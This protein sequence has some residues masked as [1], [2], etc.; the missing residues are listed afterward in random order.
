MKELF[1]PYKESRELTELGFSEECFR[2]WNYFGEK[3]FTPLHLDTSI[4]D[5]AFNYT[6][7]ILFSQA[8]KFFR[9]KYKLR[10]FVDTRVYGVDSPNQWIYDYQIKMGNGVDTEPYF[11]GDFDTYEQAELE[12]IRKMIEITKKSI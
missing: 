8:F 5:W 12:C 3:S 10:S 2:Y 1:L 11:S 4:D 9:E 7:A 6:E